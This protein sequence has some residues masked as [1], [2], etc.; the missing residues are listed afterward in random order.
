MYSPTELKKFIRYQISILSES[1]NH[2][3]FED[4]CRHLAKLRYCSN[5]I[6]ATGPVSAKGDGGID[7]PTFKTFLKEE[8]SVNSAFYGLMRN[9]GLITHRVAN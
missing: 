2:H 1:N 9:G 7:F 5:I 8:S 6:P 3:K 4:I